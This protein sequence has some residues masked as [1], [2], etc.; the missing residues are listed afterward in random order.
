MIEGGG[1]RKRE[2]RR[3]RMRGGQGQEV[4][5]AHEGGRKGGGRGVQDEKDEEGHG[6]NDMRTCGQAVVG[7]TGIEARW[8]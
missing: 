4:G 1:E 7:G 3:E 8:C 5:R 2:R 6:R